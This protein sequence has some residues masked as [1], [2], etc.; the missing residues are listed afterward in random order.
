MTRHG[1]H[2]S[3]VSCVTLRQPTVS[4]V[5]PTREKWRGRD[6]PWLNGGTC[7]NQTINKYF[8]NQTKPKP[9]IFY[10]E[11]YMDMVKYKYFKPVRNEMHAIDDFQSSCGPLPYPQ[12]PT[13]NPKYLSAWVTWVMKDCDRVQMIVYHWP[14]NGI[15]ARAWPTRGP[16]S[17]DSA[18]TGCW[19]G[20]THAGMP[21]TLSTWLLWSIFLMTVW[22]WDPS[23]M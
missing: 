21:A 4:C 19:Q 7:L 12:H 14:R 18:V 22:L 5:T 3:Y 6:Q 20:H 17:G 1:P 23:D 9:S 13:P 2:R 15:I 16:C 8:L 11:T 10:A